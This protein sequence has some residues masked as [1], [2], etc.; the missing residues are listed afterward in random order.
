MSQ[1]L[2]TLSLEERQE[3][4]KSF[5]ERHPNHIPVLVTEHKKSEV[6]GPSLLKFNVSK[7]CK[8]AEVIMSIKQKTNPT[9]TAAIYVYVNNEVCNP[10]QSIVDIDSKYR[11]ED[12][13]LYL[14]YSTENTF[15]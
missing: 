1:S 11:N 14:V 4:S 12:G 9:S 15:G 7:A 13:Y 10:S 2:S 8:I 5:R 6:K 3:K